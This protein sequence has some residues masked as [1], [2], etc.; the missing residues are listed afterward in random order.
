MMRVFYVETNRDTPYPTQEDADEVQ[1]TKAS[2][3]LYTGG[4]LQHMIPLEN[5][6]RITEINDPGSLKV[7]TNALEYALDSIKSI[8]EYNRFKY[9]EDV[10]PLV[11]P[12][13][14]ICLAIRDQ[15]K[16]EQK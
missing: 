3:H 2:V 10:L 8:L 11:M 12:I 7:K 4:R 6:L 14:E 16:D 5:V 13:I 9:V 1:F 15:R